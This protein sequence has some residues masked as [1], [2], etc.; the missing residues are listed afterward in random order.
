[1]DNNKISNLLDGLTSLATEPEEQTAEKVSQPVTTEKN[2]NKGRKNKKAKAGTPDSTEDRFTTI[3]DREVLKKIRIIATREGLN[4][5][6][7]V[8]AAFEKAIRNYE[9]KH[10]TLQETRRDTKDLF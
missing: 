1:M 5:K 8:G 3:V 4:V 6:D 7:V 2:N 10:G 9:R